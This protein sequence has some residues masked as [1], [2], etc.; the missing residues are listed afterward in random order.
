MPWNPN[1]DSPLPKK[2]KIG[3][4]WNDGVVQPHP[5]IIRALKATAKQ[6]MA[7]GHEVVN[8]DTSLHKEIQKTVVQMYFLDAGNEFWATF[9]LGNEPPVEI[10]ESFL[11]Q[12]P[13]RAYTIEETWKVSLTPS[14]DLFP[15]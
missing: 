11:Q 3:L 12:A 14:Q 8:W 4:I 1:A 2:L 5:P 10:V 15:L 6:L 13:E 7:A 9:K